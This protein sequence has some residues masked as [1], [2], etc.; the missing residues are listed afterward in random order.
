MGKRDIAIEIPDSSPDK[1]MHLGEAIIK[2]HNAL[3][4]GSPL[5][6]GKMTTLESV[7]GQART[8]K[9]EANG[10][11]ASAEKISEQ[12]RHILGIDK[13][14]NK[15][16]KGTPYHHIL[17]MRDDLLY[18]NKANEQALEEYG[19][20]VVISMVNGARRI[21]VKIPRT[22]ADKL[23]HLGE[24]IVTK[25]NGPAGNSPL[26]DEEVGELQTEVAAA[27]VKEQKAKELHAEGEN[28]NEQADTL[29]GIAGGQSL[30]TEGTAYYLI[31]DV[32]DKLLLLHEGNEEALSEYGFKVVI[33]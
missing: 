15:Q 17:G 18:A 6:N 7:V 9:G 2:K 33:S 28:L 10:K 20:T 5:D 31:D 19:Y 23:M 16:T 1:L 24:A 4:P 29:L 21:K 12:M 8:K 30:Q 3:S 22:N 32:R 11:H 13:G 26:D 27:R 25:H 14:Q